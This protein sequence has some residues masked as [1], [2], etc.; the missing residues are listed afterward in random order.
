MGLYQLSYEYFHRYEQMYFPGTE[1]GL[2]GLEPG[3]QTAR[4]SGNLRQEKVILSMNVLINTQYVFFFYPHESYLCCFNYVLYFSP[5]LLAFYMCSARRNHI[6]GLVR[7]YAAHTSCLIPNN[8]SSHSIGIRVRMDLWVEEKRCAV[9]LLA[10]SH[11]F[12]QPLH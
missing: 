2:P 5:L 12:L 8:N 10:I 3:G 4:S 1:T 6:R 11:G 7:R 9:V